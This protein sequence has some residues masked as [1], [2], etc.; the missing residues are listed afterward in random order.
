M[1][2]KQVNPT[3]RALVLL[4]ASLNPSQAAERNGRVA[5]VNGAD[6]YT[7]TPDGADV[8]R[9]THLEP[10]SSAERPSW[11]PDDKRIVYSVRFSDIPRQ[12]WMMNANG[13]NQHRLLDDPK[14]DDTDG[15]F[16]PEGKT[17][18][19]SR[20][21][22]SPHD[23]CA[24]YQVSIDGSG[25]SAITRFQPGVVDSSPIFSVDGRTIAFERRRP[26]DVPGIYLI[27]A[28]G[29][30]VRRLTRSGYAAHH[31]NWSPDGSQIAMSC[32]C[33]VSGGAAIWLLDRDGAG[34]RQLSSVYAIGEDSAM[35]DHLFPSWSPDGN[36]LAVEQRT[37]GTD[38]NVVIVNTA[39]AA[40]QHEHV[41]RLIRG[42][43]PS[44]SQAP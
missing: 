32:K 4:A 6:V 38:S 36:F 22:L 33:S 12:L 11:E 40:L 27:S 9:L 7:T 37:D 20:C 29:S 34:M 23:A 5:Y 13:R 18:V 3:I 1:I 21:Q 8:Q 24:V 10:G 15:S 2:C 26:D 25:L 30:N 14:Y 17:I 28:D 16:S 35:V 42:S 39:D 31:P 43:Q 19:F 41:K 44:W